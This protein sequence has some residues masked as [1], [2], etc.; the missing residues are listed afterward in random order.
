M[1]GH[2]LRGEAGKEE[3]VE[4]QGE[5]PKEAIVDG[6]RLVEPWSQ[7]SEQK[8]EMKICFKFF[9]K[10]NPAFRTRIHRPHVAAS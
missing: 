9:L 7:S 4:G 5:D 2:S 6:M 8:M 3:E 10:Q 1:G